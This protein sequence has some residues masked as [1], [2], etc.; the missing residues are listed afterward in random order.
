[1]KRFFDWVTEKY[2]QDRK[3][4]CLITLVSWVIV[5][6]FIFAPERSVL[7]YIFD[8][9]GTVML[10]GVIVILVALINSRSV[11]PNDDDVDDSPIKEKLR[12]FAS[13][14][15]GICLMPFVYTFAS[16][17]QIAQVVLRAVK[18]Q[19]DCD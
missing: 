16:I 13:S 15:I 10:V 7:R 9:A 14:Y 19:E 4:R 12:I 5:G 1:M 3:C 8:C 11:G 6:A 17:A 2:Y 18:H